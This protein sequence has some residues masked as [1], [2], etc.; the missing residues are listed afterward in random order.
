MESKYGRL[1]RT[2]AATLRGLYF[3]V[4]DA[5]FHDRV[6]PLI[7]CRL[8]FGHG[9]DSDRALQRWYAECAERHLGSEGLEVVYGRRHEPLGS[10]CSE[11]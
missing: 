10:Y 7:C 11:R 1:Q 5:C 9:G 3:L 8:A 2:F 4:L 6:L